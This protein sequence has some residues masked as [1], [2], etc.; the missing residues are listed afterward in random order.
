[1]ISFFYF[2][3]ENIFHNMILKDNL[4]FSYLLKTNNIH[5]A[6]NIYMLLFEILFYIWSY[7]SY[8]DNLSNWFVPIPS[9]NDLTPITK[10]LFFYFGI[11]IYYSVLF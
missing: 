2:G 7:I 1:M 9:W 6:N 3:N 5:I 10:I 8:K 11:C 4:I